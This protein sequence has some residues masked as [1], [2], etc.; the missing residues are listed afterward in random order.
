M[1]ILFGYSILVLKITS[2]NQTNLTIVKIK[3]LFFGNISEIT[4]TGEMNY[5][6]AADTDML[7]LDLKNKF[8]L[9]K[10][11]NY[12]IAV[13][14]KIINEITKLKDG[15]EIAFLPPFSGG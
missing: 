2:Q 14:M 12:R 13:N 10:N 11:F 5:S 9:L 6:D 7:E 8:P 4:G 3:L 1:S 15:D